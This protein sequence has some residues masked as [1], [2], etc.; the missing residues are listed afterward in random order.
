MRI[1]VMYFTRL[2]KWL[3]VKY[4]LIIYLNYLVFLGLVDLSSEAAARESVVDD[5]FVGL[6]AWFFEELWTCKYKHRYT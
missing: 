4:T 6:E 1:N 2:A 3:I 5:E